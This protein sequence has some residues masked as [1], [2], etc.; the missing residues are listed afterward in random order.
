MLK[1]GK[2]EKVNEIHY[3][4][5]SDSRDFTTDYVSLELEKRGV[6]YLR[7]NRD[8]LPKYNITWDIIQESLLVEINNKS[9]VI[10]EDSLKGVYYRA[11]TY[12]RETF[13]KNISVE[14]QLQQSQWMSLYRNLLFFENAKW[15]NSP[16]STF[17]AENKAIQLKVA[18]MVGF[19][20]PKTLITNNSLHVFSECESL[21]IKSLDTAVFKIN[22][23]EEA[24]VYTNSITYSELKDAELSI[25][26]VIIQQNLTPKIDYRVTV[27]GNSLFSSKIVI[28]DKGVDGDWR[29]KKDDVEFVSSELPAEISTMCCKVVKELG[30]VFGSID[31]ILHNDDFYFIEVNPTGEWAWLVDSANQEIHIAI[32]D[33][34]I[35]G[36]L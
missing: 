36:Q 17:Y 22:L 19:K 12:L 20:I 32:C 7:L 35:D 11:P 14:D 21:I 5:L 16:A 28:G 9:Y 30:L 6:K 25:S 13:S 1:P 31:I 15:I 26:P 29:K 2:I 34:L 23:E 3:L 33:N 24:F 8:Y 18:K 4:L 10:N 27:V